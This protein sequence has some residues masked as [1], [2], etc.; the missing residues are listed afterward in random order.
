MRRAFVDGARRMALGILQSFFQFGE[1]AR[2]RIDLLP[3]VRDGPVQRLN[4]LVLERQPHFQRI[5]A[6]A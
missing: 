2:Q 4:G 1:L 3:L 5:D 6:F